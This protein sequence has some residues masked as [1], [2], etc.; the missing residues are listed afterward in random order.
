MHGSFEDN[1]PSNRLFRCSPNPCSIG[2]GE[3]GDNLCY[4]WTD[5]DP[6]E[7]IRFAGALCWCARPWCGLKGT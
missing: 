1:L 6:I 4:C 7:N 5:P 2:I 3:P